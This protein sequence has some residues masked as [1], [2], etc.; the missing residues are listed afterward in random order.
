M[1]S[2]NVKKWIDDCRSKE[3][4]P[5]QNSGKLLI[6][7]IIAAAALLAGAGWL[8]RYNATHRAAEFW[9]PRVARMIRDAPIVKYLERSPAVNPDRL[10]DPAAIGHE[11]S[12]A[13]GLLHLRNALLEDRSF[14]WSGVITTDDWRHWGLLFSEGEGSTPVVIWFSKDF[15]LAASEPAKGISCEPIATGLAEMFGEFAE[16]AAER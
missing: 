4:Q 5:M 11:V 10:G 14:R 6:I 16:D 1:Q 15:R 3:P 8:F 13:R 12:H 9:G 2:R 7:G